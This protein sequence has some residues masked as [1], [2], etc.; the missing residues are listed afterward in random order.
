M[1]IPRRMRIDLYTPAELAIRNAVLAVEEMPADIRLTDAVVL[2][3]KAKEKV[4]DYV[5]SEGIV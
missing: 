2:L 5:D 1:E 3:Q 4:A